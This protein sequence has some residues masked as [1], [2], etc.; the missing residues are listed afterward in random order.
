[1]VELKACVCNWT[2]IPGGDEIRRVSLEMKDFASALID[3]FG[4]SGG[5]ASSVG[6]NPMSVMEKAGGFPLIT[7]NFQGGKLTRRS[8]FQSVEE[9]AISDD[10][11]RPPSG[12]KKR[13]MGNLSR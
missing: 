4:D 8:R 12:Y 10:E 1:M 11:F 5:L 6:E 13:D 2:D 3:A 7:E 9:V